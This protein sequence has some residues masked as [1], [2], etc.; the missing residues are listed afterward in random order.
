MFGMLR[1]FSAFLAVIK[2]S[3]VPCLHLRTTAEDAFFFKKNFRIDIE[4]ESNRTY[5][6]QDSVVNLDAQFSKLAPDG[7]NKSKAE[8][9]QEFLL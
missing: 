4:I 8:N 9:P 6:S 2:C 7:Q 3:S 1:S 5:R